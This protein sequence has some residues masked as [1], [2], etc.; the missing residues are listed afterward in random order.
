MPCTRANL[1]SLLHYYISKGN[2]LFEKATRLQKGLQNDMVRRRDE[3]LLTMSLFAGRF[4]VICKPKNTILL[5]HLF[6][7]IIL[8]TIS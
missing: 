3:L 4:R 1:L 7:C 2:E 8:E 6:L 5:H